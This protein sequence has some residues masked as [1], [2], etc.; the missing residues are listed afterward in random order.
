MQVQAWAHFFGDIDTESVLGTLANAGV[1]AQASDAPLPSMPGL[2]FYRQSGSELIEFLRQVSAQSA[3]PIVA[4]SA[5]SPAEDAVSWELLA[6]GAADVVTW[7][8]SPQVA[9]Q[10]ARRLNRWIDVE[11]LLDSPAV[12]GTLVGRSRSWR[13]TLRQ[14]VEVASFSQCPVLALGES[15]TGKELLARVI[16]ALDPRPDKGHLVV[17][18]CTTIVPELSGSEFFGH[19]RGAFTGAVAARDGAF[20]EA[21]GGSLFLDEVGE[22]PL[23]LQAQ[24]LRVV[25]ERNYKRVGSNTWRQT[26]FRLVCA[27][28]RD[29]RDGMAR[30][31]FRSDLYY[32]LSD[33]VVRL[34]PLRE[35]A[36]DVLPLTMHFLQQLN[37]E[38]SVPALD[39][40]VKRYL[41]GR[42]YP[43]NVRELR[44]LVTRI[45]HRH[46]GDGPISVGDLPEYERPK[47]GDDLVLRNEKLEQAVRLAL[48]LGASLRDISHAACEAA[49][50]IA[51]ADE[52][53]SLQRAARRLQV[54]DRA[55]QMRRAQ[56]RL[57]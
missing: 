2:V 53:G 41:A 31:T 47:A 4:I 23:V 44:Q 56:G 18:D 19:E 20:A 9:A 39:G 34:P 43:G 17:L 30:G 13:A 28:N 21:D 11:R 5:S 37:G 25:Q 50:R 6:A 36:E 46:V 29:L 27:T 42:Q 55:L 48:D 22:L 52:E 7:D 32:R 10:L 40:A 35:R 54:T 16:H 57:P 3:L 33:C 45:A 8:A 51:I 14:I 12:Q 49:I 38:G 1:L 26:S 15:G 24:L